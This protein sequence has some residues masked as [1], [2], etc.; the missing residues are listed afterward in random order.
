[1]EPA[2]DLL[3]V[4]RSDV[5][6]ALGCLSK[7]LWRKRNGVPICRQVFLNETGDASR[8][9]QWI[10]YNGF[11]TANG[12]KEKATEAAVNYL[13]ALPGWDELVVG[14][15]CESELKLFD[16]P[17]FFHKHIRWESTSHA[18]DLTKFT[19][20]SAFL[21]SLSRNARHQVRR[22]A[23]LYEEYGEQRIERAATV[24]EALVMLDEIAPMHEERWGS[25]WLG[26]GF[27]NPRFV[28]FHKLLIKSGFSE[29]KIDVIRIR[30]GAEVLGYFYN[31][32]FDSR[33]YFYLSALPRVEDNRLKP[34]LLGHSLL[35]E[36]YALA[37]FESYDFMGGGESYKDR[38]ASRGETVCRVAFQRPRPLLRLESALRRS[39]NLLDRNQ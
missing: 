1:M 28:H 7:P 38:L 23:R 31:I 14:V 20:E 39:K 17:G 30:Y 35:I 13:L 19:A 29:G 11:L 21:S 6:V 8:D 12:H 37:G 34:G 26:S 24:D 5:V 9:Q 18:T 27:S 4:R 15:A 3:V 2:F 22:T 16:N 25:G 32:L 36:R 10:E 33:V